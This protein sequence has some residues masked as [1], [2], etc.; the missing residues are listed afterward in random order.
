VKAIENTGRPHGPLLAAETAWAKVNLSLQITGRRSDGYH[1]LSSLVV[2]AD[3]GDRLEIFG[4]EAPQLSIQ[5]PYAGALDAGEDNLVR[6]AARDFCALAGLP[7][8]FA[9]VLT[10]TLPVAAGVGGGSADA[11]AVLRGL[12]G[13]AAETPDAAALHDLAL[14]LG[15][16]VPACL[17]S[18]PLIMSGIGEVLKPMACLPRVAMVLANP[19]VPLSTAAVFQRRDAP[20]SRVD[21]VPPPADLEG[22]LSWLASRG[23]DLEDPARALCPEVAQVLE[24]LSAT[25]G[26]RLARMSGSGATCFALYEEAAQAEAAARVMKDEGKGW[27]V[28][29][30]GLHKDGQR[31]GDPPDD[32][33]SAAAVE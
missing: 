28:V 21:E 18:Q 25:A 1:E 26:C 5:G 6:R 31:E 33:L 9:I 27:W 22:L 15:A 12:A 7:D 8:R 30:T 13:L 29:A 32:G 11:A 20:Y 14:S 2:F 24:A 19:G 4:A 17:A 16:D 10:K 3:I 23:N